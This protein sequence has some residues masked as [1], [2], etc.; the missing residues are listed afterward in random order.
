MQSPD[1]QL[2]VFN[3]NFLYLDAYAILM[4]IRRTLISSFLMFKTEFEKW[5]SNICRWI[6]EETKIINKCN[7][8]KA[9]KNNFSKVGK[10]NFVMKH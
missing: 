3:H 9:L 7:M 6:C 2:Q 5:S 10:T 4:L 1:V 8:H